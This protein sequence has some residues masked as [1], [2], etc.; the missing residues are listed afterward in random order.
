[1]KLSNSRYNLVI[2]I[3]EDQVTVVIAENPISLCKLTY[4]L[5]QFIDHGDSEWCMFED[6]GTSAAMKRWMMIVDPFSLDLNTKKLLD[7]IYREMEVVTK[8]DCY[9]EWQALNSQAAVL[10][11]KICS[12][13][14]YEVEFEPEIENKEL[15]KDYHVRLTET[16]E[17]FLEKLV[18]YMKLMGRI[19][20]IQG[21]FF[22]NIKSF[23]SAD[24]LE[25]LYQEAFYEKIRLVLLESLQRNR[26]SDE[27]IFLLDKDDDLI[28]F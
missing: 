25:L 11:D 22:V 16:A 18:A 13:L 28:V 9:D 14:N 2:P 21:I 17:S 10:L 4:G 3:R 24:E 19:S 26:L 8:T 23:L 20:R 1:M 27:K 15:F 7:E 6:D 5:K 12:H